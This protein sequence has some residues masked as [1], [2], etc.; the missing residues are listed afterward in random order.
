MRVLHLIDPQSPDGGPCTLRLLADVMQHMKGVGH[1]VLIVGDRRDADLAQRCGVKVTGWV[2]P[3]RAAPWA[4]ISPLR[5]AMH[6]LRSHGVRFNL[7]HSWTLRSAAQ[8]HLA[9]TGATP[10]LAT[11]HTGP[12]P[13][14][15]A[16]YTARVIARASNQPMLTASVAVMREFRSV[17]VPAHR[18]NLLPPALHPQP[19]SQPNRAAVRAHWTELTESVVGESAFVIA[20]LNEPLNWVDARSPATIAARLALSGRPVKLVVH[21]R[22]ESVALAVR[23]LENLSLGDVIIR[24]EALAEPWRI[25]A[26]VDAALSL[27]PG[28]CLRPTAS[29]L[30]LLWA[31]AAGVPIVAE[32]TVLTRDMLDDGV[33]GLLV[34]ERDSNAAA[35]RLMRLHDDPVLARRIGEAARTMVAD[36][37]GI[38]DYC[39]RL[40]HAYELLL[41]DRTVMT[42]D[43]GPRAGAQVV[44]L[45]ASRQ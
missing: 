28:V 12:K 34:N 5:K 26:G 42:I 3:P 18:I 33:N 40:K 8:A 35:V 17:G 25:M 45:H 22:V 37:Y 32:G 24:D 27:G 4:A 14:L 20:L 36:L 21:P 23:M 9:L 16:R 19:D 11:L 15:A 41:A 10:T 43:D 39:E 30:P 31:C 7:V 38:E 29:M 13:S 2:S 6:A 44:A 1:N